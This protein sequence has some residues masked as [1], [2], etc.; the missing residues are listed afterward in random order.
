MAACAYYDNLEAGLRLCAVRLSHFGEFGLVDF[1][2][3]GHM[4]VLDGRAS[5][6]SK[7][8]TTKQCSHT[9]RIQDVEM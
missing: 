8:F 1:S 2:T 7:Q 4:L 3:E 9:S 6:V 5:I